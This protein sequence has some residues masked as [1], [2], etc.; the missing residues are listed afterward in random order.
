MKIYGLS[1]KLNKEAQ[2]PEAE[3]LI[4]VPK[5]FYLFTLNW[6]RTNYDG[7]P[8]MIPW[9]IFKSW[10][11]AFEHAKENIKIIYS[12][13]FELREIENTIDPADTTAFEVVFSN[14][15]FHSREFRLYV[16]R[17]RVSFY[18]N[19][20]FIDDLGIYYLKN[21]ENV[22]YL[23]GSYSIIKYQQYIKSKN[24]ISGYYNYKGE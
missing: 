24:G 12:Q 18:E 5:S 2:L 4:K 9:G 13:E 17:Q 6:V 14:K 19:D 20:T 23:D 15:D 21:K 11:D 7:T 1:D 22:E 10:N 8:C 16:C 3:Y